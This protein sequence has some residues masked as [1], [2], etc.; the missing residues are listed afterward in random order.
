MYLA[1]NS[2]NIDS[3]VCGKSTL[4]RKSDLERSTRNH[5]EKHRGRSEIKDTMLSLQEKDKYGIAAFSQYLGE[6]NMIGRFLWHD[7][8]MRHAIAPDIAANAVGHMGFESYFWRRVRW[9]RVRKY[10]VT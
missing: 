6:D 9:I 5:E 2:T 3:C 10:M 1:I 8:G 7:G 4:F